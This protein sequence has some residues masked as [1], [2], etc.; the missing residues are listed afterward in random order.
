MRTCSLA[1]FL[2]ILGLCACED[3]T[4]VWIE[5]GSTL[6]HLTFAI[7]RSRYKPKS[8]RI[9][10]FRVDRCLYPDCGFLSP[11]W[12]V[13]GSRAGGQ[14]ARIVYGELPVGFDQEND[15]MPLK[16]GRYQVTM[17]GTGRLRFEILPDGTVRELAPAA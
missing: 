14:T 11:M 10:A 15:P 13:G 1:L 4:A 5:Q 8:L 9:G 3:K 16:P 17:S 2:V 6:N 12:I 7:G